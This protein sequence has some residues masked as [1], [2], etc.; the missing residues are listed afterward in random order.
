MRMLTSVSRILS[1][2][3][4]CFQCTGCPRCLKGCSYGN[5]PKP[6][7]RKAKKQLPLIFMGNI[8]SLPRSEKSRLPGFSDT[9]AHILLTDARNKPR[10]SPDAHRH[11]RK[12]LAA[13]GGGAERGP[14][15]RSLAGQLRARYS[16]RSPPP[17]MLTAKPRLNAYLHVLPFSVKVKIL[18]RFLLVS[19][20]RYRRSRSFATQ[21]FEKWGMHVS[22]SLLISPAI[23]P[24]D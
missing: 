1:K 18:L 21:T 19:E 9:L 4:S 6:K 24:T 5:F 22:L 8:V 7:W 11:P 14:R 13:G 10:Q 15:G 23:P 17:R 12:A 2:A 16:G 3:D 20:N